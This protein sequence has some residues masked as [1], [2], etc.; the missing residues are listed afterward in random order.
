MKLL[1]YQP[2][3]A[4]DLGVPSQ[5]IDRV[6]KSRALSGEAMEE[7]INALFHLLPGPPNGSASV[8]PDGFTPEGRL[9]PCEI[10]SLKRGCKLPL[11][12]FRLAKDL[13]ET[14]YFIGVHKR[15]KCDN[16][17][18]I[19]EG[20]AE[21]LKEVLIIPHAELVKLA[22]AQ[23]LQTIKSQETASGARNGYQRKGYCEGYRNVPFQTLMEDLRPLPF[24]VGA[25]L[26]GLRF[27][28]RVHAHPTIL[29]P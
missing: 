17:R 25:E 11:Y 22:Q 18:G 2:S 16:L 10:K 19:W 24:L 12:D 13:P 14:L 5:P 28:V 4:L 3:L 21:T 1:K 9:L 29:T 15:G 20:M 27:Q 7:V 8:C 6:G 26:H 23:P